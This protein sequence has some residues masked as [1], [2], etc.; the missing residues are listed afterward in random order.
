MYLHLI[1]SLLFGISVNI[2]T[3][4]LAMSYGIKK[5]HI[6]AAVNLIISSITFLGTIASI[7]L[8]IRIAGLIPPGFSDILGS[9]VLI[10]LG[11]YY[12]LKFFLS[13]K[14]SQSGD[15]L[16]STSRC[17]ISIKEAVLLSLALTINNAGMGIGASISGMKMIPT[18][19]VTLVCCIAF[20][21]IGNRVGESWI[22]AVIS[23]VADPLSGFI[24]IVLGAIELIF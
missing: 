6:S 1:S 14:S 21:H 17:S 24:I 3:F 23:R 10:V 16:K 2:D 15:D 18:S 20:L 5:I 22:S 11:A 9:L 8:G 12:L 4:I 7:G 19:V 13:R